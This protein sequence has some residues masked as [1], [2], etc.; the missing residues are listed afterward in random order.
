[1][2][3]RAYIGVGANLG[4]PAAQVRAALDALASLGPLRASSLYRTEPLGDPAQPWYV[5]AVAE[6]QTQLSPTDL[7]A[8]LQALEVQAGRP[9]PRTAGRAAMVS[10]LLDLDLLLFGDVRSGDP[11]LRLPHP[12]LTK[13]RFVLEPLA[14]IA[15]G[16]RVPGSGRAVRELLAELEDPL[17]V[18]KLPAT[19]HDQNTDDERPA[20]SGG[21]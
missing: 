4:D 20:R 11:S 14:E 18:E 1:M 2:S 21:E 15:P 19:L 8:R 13:R 6:L 5:N 12:G 16:A 9:A 17:R 3:T 10:R 7:L